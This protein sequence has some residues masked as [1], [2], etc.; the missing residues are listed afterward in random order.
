RQQGRP[1]RAAGKAQF[2]ARPA[3]GGGGRPEGRPVGFQRRPQFFPQ[4]AARGGSWPKGRKPIERTGP[5]ACA[6]ADERRFRAPRRPERFRRKG[7]YGRLEWRLPQQRTLS[8]SGERKSPRRLLV[9]WSKGG[10]R[11]APPAFPRAP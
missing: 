1:E 10:P 4:P 9:L 3:I 2:L 11:A 5:E 7:T 6:H 8:G